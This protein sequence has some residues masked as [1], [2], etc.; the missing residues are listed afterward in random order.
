[1]LCTMSYHTMSVPVGQELNVEESSCCMCWKL[2]HMTRVPLMT[3]AFA[4][5]M[6]SHFNVQNTHP[7]LNITI[8]FQFLFCNQQLLSSFH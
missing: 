1:M 5:V 7:Y 3:V 6:S 4:A 8:H 2:K